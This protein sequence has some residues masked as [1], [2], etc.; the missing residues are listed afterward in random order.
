MG[1]LALVTVVSLLASGL[2]ACGGGGAPSKQDFTAEAN[3]ACTD[4]TRKLTELNLEQGPA[5]NPQ[6]DAKFGAAQLSVREQNLKQMRQIEPSTEEKQAYESYLDLRQKSLDAQQAVITALKKNDSAAV[7][8]LA[9]KF[10]E[11]QA[12]VSKAA[13]ELGLDVCAAKLSISDS[14]AVGGVIGTYE[15]TA[16]P[17]LACKELVTPQ[18]LKITDVTYSKCAAALE[19]Q[20]TNGELPESVDVT[21]VEGVDGTVATI[22]FKDVGGKYD[23]VPTKATLVYVDGKWKIFNLVST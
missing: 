17:K 5:T 6:E 21:K 14:K 13:D 20:N 16:D 1:K 12:E 8:Q 3:K 4:G 2:A 23:G 15:A 18:F 10:T 7:K 19:K 9:A 22:E 11:S